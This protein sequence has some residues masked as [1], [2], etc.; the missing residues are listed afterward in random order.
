MDWATFKA[1]FKINIQSLCSGG[2]FELASS[3]CPCP[4]NRTPPKFLQSD[5]SLIQI[6]MERYANGS[7]NLFIKMK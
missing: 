4:M 2:R 7:N 1:V 5:I 6:T 3:T